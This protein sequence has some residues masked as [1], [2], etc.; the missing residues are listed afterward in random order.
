MFP[1][2]KLTRIMSDLIPPILPTQSR[3]MILIL[4]LYVTYYH[5]VV[6]HLKREDKTLLMVRN[7]P[8]TLHQLLGEAQQACHQ[9]LA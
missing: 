9:Q 5:G 6:V 8:T 4:I 2:I 3:S 1:H 7:L